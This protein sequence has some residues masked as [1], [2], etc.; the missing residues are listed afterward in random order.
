[1]KDLLNKK[2]FK[3]SETTHLYV[4]LML[5]DEQTGSIRE[6]SAATGICG[7]KIK[8]CIR[9]LEASNDLEVIKENGVR[10]YKILDN[11]N[12]KNENAGSD[13]SQ[14]PEADAKEK[15]K[16]GLRHVFRKW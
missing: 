4:Y 3:S 7:D 9:R 13:D 15:S 5:S 12:T 16:G 11:E 10:T 6:L 14:A 1:M 2:W 8:F